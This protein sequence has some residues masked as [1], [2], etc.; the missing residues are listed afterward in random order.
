MSEDN[1]VEA[2][3]SF[4]LYMV[5]SGDQ[6]QVNSLAWPVLYRLSHLTRPK[7]KP[8]LVLRIVM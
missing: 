4:Y 2:I 6:T 8:V 5:G 1:F 3:F 7:Y